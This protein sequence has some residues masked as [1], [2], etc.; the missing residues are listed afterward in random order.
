MDCA[1][2]KPVNNEVVENSILE[3]GKIKGVGEAE[4]GMTIVKS[5]RTTGLTESRIRAIDSTVRVRL[6]PL[7]KPFLLTKSL[8]THF[9]RAGTAVPLSWIRKTGPSAC[10]LPGPTGPPSAI[11][12][13]MSWKN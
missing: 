11:K 10:S 13:A 1:V 8:L 4:I 9:Q 12:S 7:R 2:A 3:I 5:G 6:D